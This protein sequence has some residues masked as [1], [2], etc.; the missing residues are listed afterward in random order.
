[1]KGTVLD[2]R[3]AAI[4]RFNRF[5]TRQIGALQAE[6][7]QSD[8]SLAEVRVLYEVAQQDGATATSIGA[9]LGLDPGYLSRM[10]RS[11]EASALVQRRRSAD[12]G[13]RAL[14]SL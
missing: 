8:L 2:A 5:Y 7:L 11:L 3:I 14:L 4:R 1:M 12:D 10:L 13:R 9:T 6:Y